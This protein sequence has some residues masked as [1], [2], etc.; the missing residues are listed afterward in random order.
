MWGANRLKA[1]WTIPIIMS[2]G[3]TLRVQ[4]WTTVVANPTFG[5]SLQDL[6][7]YYKYSLLQ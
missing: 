1:T 5:Q 2:K 7:I 3:F 6:Y 4:E